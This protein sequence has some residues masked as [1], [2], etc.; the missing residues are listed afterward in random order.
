[1]ATQVGLLRPLFAKSQAAAGKCEMKKKL[2]W[3]EEVPV[4]LPLSHLTRQTNE[5][6]RGGIGSQVSRITNLRRFRNKVHSHLSLAQT[7]ILQ[8]ITFFSPDL[9]RFTGDL[10]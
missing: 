6:G 2:Q 9:D 1:M 8:I 3:C 10:P 7:R 4:T 5:T